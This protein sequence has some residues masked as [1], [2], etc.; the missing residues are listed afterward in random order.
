MIL[1]Q[2]Y[3]LLAA[4]SNSTMKD[5][6]KEG[7]KFYYDN[8]VDPDKPEAREWATESTDIG[9]LVDCLITQPKVFDKFYYISGDVKVSADFRKVL[10][11]TWQLVLMFLVT[12]K[13]M[14]QEDALKSSMLRD[15][16]QALPF[17]LSAA[18]NVDTIDKEGKPAKGYRNN[19]GDEALSKLLVND[20]ASYYSVLGTANGR[21]ILDQTT[22]NVAIKT[23]DSVLNH[24]TIGKMFDIKNNKKQELFGQLMVTHSINGMP[25]KIL[26][27]YVLFDHVA[28]VIYPKD[29]KT[30]R[31]HKQFMLNYV[32][33]D[34]PNQGSFYSGVLKA[35]YPGYTI[36]PFEFIVCCTDSGEDPIIY[37]MSETELIVARDGAVLKTGRT[38]KGWMNLVNQ[39]KWHTENGLWRYPKEVYDNGHILLNTYNDDAIESAGEL[40]DD[41]F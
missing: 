12:E 29:V 30:A 18:R 4:V 11:N 28:K 39:I 21:K 23:K 2:D 25:C 1:D 34:Y 15:I 31:S 14:K 37:R 36:A 6:G 32:A 26:L 13:K 8:Y 7:P 41:I 19:Y 3:R 24:E 16:N 38:V 10:D 20:G 17:A 40:M 33:Y 9:D 27:D 22:Y 5:F 35:A